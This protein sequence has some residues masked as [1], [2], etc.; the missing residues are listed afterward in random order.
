M[1]QKYNWILLNKHESLPE[2]SG[3]SKRV[4]YHRP[5]IVSTPGQ[6]TFVHRP[7]RSALQRISS[8]NKLNDRIRRRL[9]ENEI[10]ASTS[11]LDDSSGQRT[12][13]DEITGTS[14][15]SR[16]RANRVVDE[17][18]EFIQ[19]EPDFSTPMT[20]Q[21]AYTREKRETND[22]IF[23]RRQNETRPPFFRTQRRS[24][25]DPMLDS[26][27]S[28]GPP[29]R[30]HH[31][32]I[33]MVRKR[34]DSLD[35]GSIRLNFEF[36]PNPTPMTAAST[37]WQTSNLSQ[38]PS[39]SQRKRE[40]FRS[41]R[42]KRPQFRHRQF[43]ST[44]TR[45]SFS[46]FRDFEQNPPRRA[47]KRITR[48]PARVLPRKTPMTIEPYFEEEE[49]ETST[50]SSEIPQAEFSIPG[51]AWAATIPPRTA[52]QTG[53]YPTGQIFGTSRRNDTSKILNVE[54]LQRH[55]SYLNYIRGPSFIQMHPTSP[56]SRQSTIIWPANAGPAFKSI[57]RRPRASPVFRY[58]KSLPKWLYDYD[59]Y[60]EEQRQK[61]NERRKRKVIALTLV[62][63][64]FALIV[65]AGVVLAALN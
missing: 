37:D 9:E 6:A 21:D 60:A 22:S 63:L 16:R 24:L 54:S 33:R 40:S 32:P 4:V 18:F 3:A 5:I 42:E 31:V 59:A 30:V 64:F 49:A 58:G 14:E 47:S 44:S 28:R 61:E 23:D 13:P 36:D 46:E 2:Y 35:S 1:Q 11:I 26:E 10:Y 38:K 41:N 39:F 7:T 65:A 55:P 45:P 53:F 20:S 12:R 17:H 62:F 57:D 34:A 8:I 29:D 52:S 51:K 19:E 25:T 27:S 50:S 43:P 48:R 56:T 15:A